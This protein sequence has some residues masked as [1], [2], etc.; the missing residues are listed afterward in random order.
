MSRV[1]RIRAIL[2]RAEL[3]G[4]K[5]GLHSGRAMRSPILP[6]VTTEFFAAVERRKDLGNPAQPLVDPR[7]VVT[8]DQEEQLS[9]RI[10]H[11]ARRQWGSNT[12]S[13]S[14]RGYRPTVAPSGRSRLQR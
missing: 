8:E 14:E 11:L 10:R 2:I 5:S 12:G 1:S 9:E 4:D 6:P 13:P 3:L 7:F